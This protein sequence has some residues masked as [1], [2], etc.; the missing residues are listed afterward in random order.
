MNMSYGMYR[1]TDYRSEECSMIHAMVMHG[2]VVPFVAAG[3]DALPS[4]YNYP[5]TCPFSIRVGNVY[6]N[7]SEPENLDFVAPDS[8]YY[9]DVWTT[10]QASISACSNPERVEG[11][12][13]LSKDKDGVG[14]SE[15]YIPMTGTSM[16]SPYAAGVAAMYQA[17]TKI[18]ALG[19][20]DLMTEFSAPLAT[21][22]PTVRNL[23]ANNKILR[24]TFLS[25][26]VF[27]VDEPIFVLK[28][29][30]STVTFQVR[31][32]SAPTA[33][34][35][36]TPTLRAPT[37][38]IA[39]TFTPATLTFTSGDWNTYQTMTVQLD[40]DED[41]LARSLVDD[42]SGA[43]I[44]TTGRI[45]TKYAAARPHTWRP[46][47][48]TTIRLEVTSTTD[49]DMD[50]GRYAVFV[51]DGRPHHGSSVHNPIVVTYV[52]FLLLFS[53]FLDMYQHTETNTIP[54]YFLLFIIS[55]QVTGSNL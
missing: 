23:T 6:G 1:F 18:H 16:A 14:C 21:A 43:V 2:G 51:L 11:V 9:V 47:P 38:N 42:A 44:S 5:Q 29:R 8:T 32:A 26:Q 24:S 22:L 17:H 20:Y 54:F 55:V 27:V 13:D 45:A 4:G 31:L 39:V 28:D 53:F 19:L 36:V 34:V 30:F 35:T 48:G 52:F 46:V 33:N 41:A 10:G 7:P 49:N 37:A 12:V 40:M 25:K 3:N 15:R 50:G